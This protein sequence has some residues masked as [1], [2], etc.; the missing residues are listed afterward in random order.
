MESLRFV[1]KDVAIAEGIATVAYPGELPSDRSYQ[2]VHVKQGGKWLIDSLR[3]TL[4]PA[5]EVSETTSI[6]GKQPKI[7]EKLKELE[8]MIGNW[9]E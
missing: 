9:L 1:T 4:L 8:W 2:V 6:D 7:A 3:D 5:I